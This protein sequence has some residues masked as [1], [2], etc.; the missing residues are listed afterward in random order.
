VPLLPALQVWRNGF[1]R[2]KVLSMR[3]APLRPL[4]SLWGRLL[5]F[6]PCASTMPRHAKAGASPGA[7]PDIRTI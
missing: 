2:Q 6:W 4:R 5:S 3:A 7:L 1:F